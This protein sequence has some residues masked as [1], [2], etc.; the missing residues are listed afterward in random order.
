MQ[1]LGITDEER[2]VIGAARKRL[3]ETGFP[4]LAIQLDDGRV[5]TG[6]TSDLMGPSA[7]VMLNAL[8][9]VAGIEKPVHVI[10]P[11]VIGPVQELKC[12]YLGNHNPRLHSDEILIALSVSAATDENAARALAALPALKGCEAHSTVIL[13]AADANTFRRIVVAVPERAQFEPGF[14][15]W[16]ER[17][18]RLAIEIGCR[19][20]FHAH[21]ETAQLIQG[22]L[23]HY[24]PLIRDEY[25]PFSSDASLEEFANSLSDDHLFVLVTAR[26]G[27]ISYEKRMSRM[28]VMMQKYFAQKSFMLVFPDQQG[29]A[30]DVPTFIEP[31]I[32][33]TSG[34]S[35]INRWL[36]RWIR[37]IG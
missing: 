35:P 31:H 22:Y 21:E 13:S 16:V 29:E 15:R 2:P 20:E 26:H 24:H 8:K 14:Y 37:K 27:T 11:T 28:Q 25:R 3:E 12:R 33:G 34:S 9:A 7:A 1:Q 36:S 4:A 30:V 10:S 5:I 32:H 23:N 18:A 6:K 17:V 19:V